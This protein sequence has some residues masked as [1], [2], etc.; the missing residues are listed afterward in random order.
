MSDVVVFKPG[1][2]RYIKGGFQFSS[3]VAAETGFEIERARLLRPLPLSAGFAAVEAH[4]SALARPSTAFAPCGL[5]SAEP[6][7][8]KGFED[9]N[10]EYVK[11]LARCGLYRNDAHPASATN[12]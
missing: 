6:F 1:G 7:T 11:T 12:P 3:G 10:R 9:F 8:A 4:L 2:Y 5:R